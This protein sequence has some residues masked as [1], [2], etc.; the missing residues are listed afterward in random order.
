MKLDLSDAI[1]GTGL[2][3]L[4][5]CF[6]FFGDTLA[7]VSLCVLVVLYGFRLGVNGKQ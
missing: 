1:I 5:S 3:G 2:L 7:L 4:L 6:W